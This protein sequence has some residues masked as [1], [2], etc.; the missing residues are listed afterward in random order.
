MKDERDIL[1]RLTEL[2]RVEHPGSRRWWA[3]WDAHSELRMLRELLPLLDEEKWIATLWDR[4]AVWSQSTFG[5]DADRN[6]IGPLRHLQKEAEE[7]L[8]N[9][10][11][12]VEFADCFLLVLDAARRAG[13]SFDDLRIAILRK[14]AI[15]ERRRWLKPTSDLPAEH[16]RGEEESEHSCGDAECIVP[17]PAPHKRPPARRSE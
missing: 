7:A 1:V 5:S 9:P 4:L 8:A 3:L 6:H 12:V 10:G 13:H 2:M 17:R 14:Y 16:I 15:N 11:D